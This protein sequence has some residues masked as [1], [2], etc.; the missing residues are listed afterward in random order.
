M[1]ERL[2]KGRRSVARRRFDQ[3]TVGEVFTLPATLLDEEHFERFQKLTGDDHPMHY[4]LED[5][6][7]RGH[8]ALLAHGLQV[9]AL[10]AAGAGDF[11]FVVE[12]SIVGFIEQSARF[13]RP[14]LCGDT[15]T[16]SLEITE[17]RGQRTTGVV[18]LRLTILNQRGEL[19]VEG[20]Q[21][22]LLRLE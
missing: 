12:D 6:R 9:L 11:P 4:D 1:S 14:A 19:V 10:S 21:S 20:S 13:L 8:P 16:P 15:L 18:V 22:Y 17:L 3:L 2:R 5:C 7:R